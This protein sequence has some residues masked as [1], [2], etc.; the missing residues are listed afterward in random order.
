[1]LLGPFMTH[2][3]SPAAKIAVTH[4]TAFSTMW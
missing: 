1:M 2:C 4:N 3:G